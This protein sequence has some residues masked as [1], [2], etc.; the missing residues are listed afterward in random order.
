MNTEKLEK[1]IR[2]NG[3]PAEDPELLQPLNHFWSAKPGRLYRYIV[4]AFNYWLKAPEETAE[5]I[6]YIC[7]TL[8][9][10]LYL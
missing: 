8:L 10:P 6:A 2:P 5:K 3:Q 1:L 9:A 4:P 7:E